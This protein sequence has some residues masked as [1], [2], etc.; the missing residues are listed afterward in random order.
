MDDSRLTPAMLEDIEY[1]ITAT[2]RSWQENDLIKVNS[3]AVL[4]RVAQ[5]PFGG[6][7]SDFSDHTFG[8]SRH[9]AEHDYDWYAENVL[10]KAKACE[11]ARMD[12]HEAVR[13]HPG[14]LAYENG[15]FP[16]GGATYDALNGLIVSVSGFREDEDILFAHTVRNFVVML[17]DRFGQLRIDDARQRGELEGEEGA[18]RFTWTTA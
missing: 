7:E 6:F 13:R 10:G 17:L 12:S 1:F 11:V 2:I 14:A 3:Y 15:T 9:D 8:D 18:N 16:W 5:R 4:I